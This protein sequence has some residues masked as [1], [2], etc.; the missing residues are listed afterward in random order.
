MSDIEKALQLATQQRSSSANEHLVLDKSSV[1]TAANENAE[2]CGITSTSL[3]R[4]R[5]EVS[6]L[7]PMQSGAYKIP[8]PDA[9]IDLSDSMS[10]QSVIVPFKQ[11]A[12][13][14][15]LTP[16]TPRSALLEQ[17]RRIKRP[18]LKR[19]FSEMNADRVKSRIIMVTSAKSG[20]GKTFSAINLAMSITME[21]DNTVLFIDADMHKAAS[22]SALGLPENCSGLTDYLAS[23][24]ANYTDYIY[25]TQLPGLHIMPAGTAKPN[26]TE[27]FAS[28]RMAQ[29]LTNL[30]AKSNRQLIVVDTPPLLQTT[31]ASAIIDHAGQIAFVVAA[32]ITPRSVVSDAIAQ[33]SREQY[34]GLILNKSRMVKADSYAYGY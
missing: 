26:S 30:C 5:G 3:L 29:L 33:I 25:Q 17:Y 23:D 12:A 20:E 22:S 32:E 28:A 2:D 10:E 19:A 11:L 27:L 13:K 7:R 1:Q 8:E 6:V 14:N 9:F 15:Y 4:T 31:E 16:A 34:V 21:Q 24:T 18:L